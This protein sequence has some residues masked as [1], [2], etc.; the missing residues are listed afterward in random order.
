M[1][2]GA[3]VTHGRRFLR[4]WAVVAAA[5]AAILAAGFALTAWRQSP[6]QAWPWLLKVGAV[7]AFQLLLPLLRR[8]AALSG[9]N[10]DKLWGPAN[11]LTWVRGALV[12]LLAGYLFAPEPEGWA[13]WAPALLF[14]LAV[15]LD[16]VDGWWARRTASQTRLGALLDLEFDA[17]AVLLGVSLA[18]YHERLP[19]PFLAVGAARYLFVAGMALRRSRGL[20]LLELPPS[21]LRRRLAGF[22]MGV[23]AVLLWP[24]AAPPVTTV[25]E[26]LVA[27][28]LLAG[29]LRDWLLVSGRLDPQ[30]PGYRR[31]LRASA[32]A[33]YRW[34]PLLLRGLLAAAAVLG[35]IQAARPGA[36]VPLLSAARLLLQGMLV[37][38]WSTAPAALLLLLLEGTRLFTAGADLP[39]LLTV[40]CALLLYLVGPGPLSLRPRTLRPQTRMGG[41]AG[42]LRYLP[43]LAVP[44]LLYWAL[45]EV[46]FG[47]ILSVLGRLRGLP[48]LTLLGVNALFVLVLTARWGL[49]LRRLGARVPLPSLA[50]YRL[51][52]FAVSYLTPGPQF[53]GEP[54]QLL[55]ARRGSGLEYTTGSASILL[56]KSFELLGNLLF[57]ALGAWAIAAR[58]WGGQGSPGLGVDSWALF[59]VPGV[60]V[61]PPLL[62]LSLSF[63]G[64]RPLSWLAD[65]LP[66]SRRVRASRFRH[67]LGAAEEQV[68]AFGRARGYAVAFGGLSFLLV[69]SLTLAETWLA[70]AFLGVPVGW[71]EVVILLAGSRFA[72][73]L[74]FPAALG[75]LELTQ[76]SLFALLGL[77]VESAWALLL[78]VRGRDL[79]VAGIGL[80]AMTIG[81]RR[82]P[83]AP[84]SQEPLPESGSAVPV[85]PREAE[86]LDQPRQ[87]GLHPGVG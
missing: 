67:L 27:V 47:E 39:G 8:S 53:G 83:R 56:D 5:H 63:A 37:A 54:V 64:R 10:L 16:F 35:V 60:L 32:R 17:L 34:A 4:G 84:T 57:L 6:A 82:R 49:I 19:L 41:R 30:G 21:Y 74:P 46:R 31:L 77:P 42:W 24:I 71:L 55:L 73:L 69:W 36:A 15:S 33:A 48:L 68:I 81:L 45:R 38:G 18:V 86:V 26:A 23:L 85:S 65:H 40:A 62:Y 66:G 29:F 22:Q 58:G 14:T 75:A 72:F 78:Y 80:L 11:I 9:E 79:L 50:G 7:L 61:L 51:A 28:P 87:E 25:A 3:A 59:L 13:A 43:W 76:V 20:P 52:G 70:L 1:R 2:A 12:A 44:L